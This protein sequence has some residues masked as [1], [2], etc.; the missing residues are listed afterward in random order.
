MTMVNRRLNDPEGLVFHL[1]RIIES[2]N[3]IPGDLCS[4]GYWRCF[5]KSWKQSDF[6][7]FGKF[8]DANL[9]RISSRQVV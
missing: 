1:E 4:Y 3:F 9:E 6:L 8:L 5:D 7:N 2:K